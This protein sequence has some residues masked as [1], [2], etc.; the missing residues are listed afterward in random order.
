MVSPD[1]S[2]ERDRSVRPVGFLGRTLLQSNETGVPSPEAMTPSPCA[3]TN[4][5]RAEVINVALWGPDPV[6]PWG[7]GHIRPLTPG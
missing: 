5:D 3:F 4:I 2:A 1:G 7:L 6:T